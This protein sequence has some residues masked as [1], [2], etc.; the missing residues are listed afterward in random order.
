[1]TSYSLECTSGSGDSA[2]DVL[3]DGK[4]ACEGVPGRGGPG[5]V[6]LKSALLGWPYS[7]DRSWEKV[8]ADFEKAIKALNAKR[9]EER[10]EGIVELPRCVGV[11]CNEGCLVYDKT[12]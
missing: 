1:M 5:P 10:M 8:G 11:Q 6:R 2:D 4:S 12:R 9:M 7:A 3:L